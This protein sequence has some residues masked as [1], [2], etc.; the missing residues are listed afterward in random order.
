[1]LTGFARMTVLVDD[2]DAALA[3]YGDLLGF[4]PVYDGELDDGTRIRHVCLPDQEPVG[5]WLLEPVDD[6]ARDRVGAQT[7]GEPSMGRYTDDCRGDCARLEA[8]GIDVVTGPVSTPDDVHA[9]ISDPFGNSVVLVERLR[10]HAN[11]NHTENPILP[12]IFYF[13]FL[14]VFSSTR[15][16]DIF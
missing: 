13:Y 15:S 6:T 7:G 8:D 5:V 1:M 2:F 11:N 3:F 9:H 12:D 4:E 16:S 10:T 14:I